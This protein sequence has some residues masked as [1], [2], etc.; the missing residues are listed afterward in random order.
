ML[1]LM[2]TTGRFSQVRDAALVMYRFHLAMAGDQNP[3]IFAVLAIYASLAGG[4]DAS[5]P[6]R[7]LRQAGSG[8]D[9]DPPK[10]DPRV[11][12]L[13]LG[14]IPAA[15]N[16]EKETNANT[17]AKIR[18]LLGCQALK[19]GNRQDAERHFTSGV[20]DGDLLRL[21]RQ[22]LDMMQG[23]HTRL[24]M[25]T[26]ILD[27]IDAFFH[28][29]DLGFQIA[30]G[31]LAE[32]G[33][34]LRNIESTLGEA[35]TSDLRGELVM[36]VLLDVEKQRRAGQKIQ[37]SSWQGLIRMFE[38]LAG[39]ERNLAWRDSAD[40]YQ[41]MHIAY[42]CAGRPN[43]SRELLAKAAQ[44]AKPLPGNEK[45]FCVKTLGNVTIDEFLQINDDMERSLDKGCLWDGTVLGERAP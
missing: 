14:E 13:L 7:M 15:L 20:K 35:L 41:A 34:S 22:A 27:R 45:I 31:R 9:N 18:F 44:T 36:R 28:W 32:P 17:R 39:G 10:M 8:S 29:L 11:Y 33:P 19:A 12:Q 40:L 5:E 30:D 43:I 26:N 37:A 2:L 25:D 6:S 24:S 4:L 21:S 23:T 42:A 1:A 3:R 16:L 38:W